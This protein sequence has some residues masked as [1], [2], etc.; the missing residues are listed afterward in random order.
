MYE[1]SLFS[2]ERNERTVR[3]VGYSS[4]RFPHHRAAHFRFFERFNVVYQS[5]VGCHSTLAGSVQ[6]VKQQLR[7]PV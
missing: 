4:Y 1:K 2:N 3:A 6:A 5:R 7:Y